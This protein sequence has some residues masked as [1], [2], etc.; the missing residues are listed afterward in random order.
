MSQCRLRHDEIARGHNESI[1]AK[2][3]KI[4]AMSNDPVELVVLGSI[5]IT[6]S[7]KAIH[8]STIQ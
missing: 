3:T 5:G 7:E 2:Y 8:L 6:Y 4:L 1:V